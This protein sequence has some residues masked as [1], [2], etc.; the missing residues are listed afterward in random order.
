[1]HLPHQLPNIWYE[2]H[3][4]SGS[5]DV[6]GVT[7]PGI[8]YVIVGHN[9]RIAWGFTN[10]GPAVTDLFVETFNDRGEYLTPE[11]WRPPEHRRETIVV[12]GGRNQTVDI[13][14]TRHGPIVSDAQLPRAFGRDSRTPLDNRRRLALK[15]TLYDPAALQVPFFDLNSAQNWDEFRRALAH[16]GSPA[17]NVV[18]ADVDGHIG[19]QAAGMIPIRASA[20][21]PPPEDGAPDTRNGAFPVPGDD[22]RHEWTGSVPLSALPSLLDPPSGILATANGRI[23]PDGYPYVLATDWGSPIATERIYQLL[24][25]GR[26]SRRA[27]MLAVQTDIYSD[28]DHFCAQQMVDA[29]ERTPGASPRAGEAGRLLAAWDGRLTVDSAAATLVTRARRHLWRLLLEPRWRPGPA[30]SIPPTVAVT[31][32]RQYSWFS[33]GGQENILLANL[34]AGCPPASPATT[35]C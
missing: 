27:D 1:M 22:D 28:F 20:S 7:L 21:A 8:P 3:L 33:L 4:T 25:S 30:R 35:S 10:V 11:G 24:E 2:A 34:H 15:W 6:A 23:T 13:T 32:W 5:Y 16:F 29:V 14:I 26:S 12:R 9:Q 31:G 19:Y 18:Y 17:Q